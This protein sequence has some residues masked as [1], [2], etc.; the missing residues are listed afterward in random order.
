L[1]I[2]YVANPT[3]PNSALNAI[4]K[5]VLQR[6]R[7]AASVEYIMVSDT[8][9]LDPGLAVFQVLV[10]DTLQD[11]TLAKYLT[12]VSR[13]PASSSRERLGLES[14]LLAFLTARGLLLPVLRLV[15][16]VG[17]CKQEPT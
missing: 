2:H 16:W 8:P 10:C 15:A 9:F 11:K 17:V 3:D 6:A 5:P 14:S 13:K 7:G 12:K 4:P 1:C